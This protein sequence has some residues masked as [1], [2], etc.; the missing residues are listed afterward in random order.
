MARLNWRDRALYDD[1]YGRR[2][3]RWFG[4]GAGIGLI[5]V[6]VAVGIFDT[7]EAAMQITVIMTIAGTLALMAAWRAPLILS[8]FSLLFLGLISA[9]WRLTPGVRRLPTPDDEGDKHL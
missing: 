8:P 7:S 5:A 3:D 9:F 2:F 4:V 6:G 1:V